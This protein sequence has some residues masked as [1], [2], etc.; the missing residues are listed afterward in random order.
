[1]AS[2]RED[3]VTS[4]RTGNGTIN[5]CDS[6]C[7]EGDMFT[8]RGTQGECV[9]LTEDNCSEGHSCRRCTGTVVDSGT[10][11]HQDVTNTTELVLQTH[12]SHQSS[13]LLTL[14]T[15]DQHDDTI[16]V[17]QGDDE[18][19]ICYYQSIRTITLTI[20]QPLR[21]MLIVGLTLIW[22]GSQQ[23]SLKLEKLVKLVY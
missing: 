23:C 11:R 6:V 19:L 16:P 7:K 21:N 14:V 13:T 9:L 17:G 15:I 8:R 22:M 10:P 12:V 3:H 20:P 1:M 4:H 2:S 18:A 5:H